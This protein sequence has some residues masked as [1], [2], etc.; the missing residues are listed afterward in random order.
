MKKWQRTSLFLIGMLVAL[1][2]ANAVG[3]S[4]R[5][6]AANFLEM[7]QQQPA[8]T[9]IMILIGIVILIIYLRNRGG[10]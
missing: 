1:K 5:N 3:I 6:A 7:Q 10:K 8:T 4:F 9:N 2:S